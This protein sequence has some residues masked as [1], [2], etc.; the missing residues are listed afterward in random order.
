MLQSSSK[1][2]G[3]VKKSTTKEPSSKKNHPVPE[4]QKQATRINV[5]PSPNR[6]HRKINFGIDSTEVVHFTHWFELFYI[7]INKLFLGNAVVNMLK[8]SLSKICN[9]DSEN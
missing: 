7:H 9:E 4:T 6:K 5:I 2:S 3:D 1:V 8:I